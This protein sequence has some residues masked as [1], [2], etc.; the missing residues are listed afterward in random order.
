MTYSN[1]IFKA[2][3]VIDNLLQQQKR[4][5]IDE[6]NAWDNMPEPYS[7]LQLPKYQL[8][9]IQVNSQDRVAF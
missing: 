3:T 7:W 1:I 9:Q 2:G 6:N 4:K 5:Y 8:I